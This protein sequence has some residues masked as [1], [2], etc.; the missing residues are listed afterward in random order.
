MSQLGNS[1]LESAMTAVSPKTSQVPLLSSPR[2]PRSLNVSQPMSQSTPNVV[3]TLVPTNVAPIPEN[4]AYSLSS[5]HTSPSATTSVQ[6][7]TSSR[8]SPSRSGRLSPSLAYTPAGSSYVS[9]STTV[10]NPVSN[11]YVSPLPPGSTQTFTNLPALG[12]SMTTTRFSPSRSSMASQSNVV[13]PMSSSMY[14]TEDPLYNVSPRSLV[15]SQPALASV[16]PTASTLVGL[17]AYAQYPSS[18]LVGS[19]ASIHYPSSA[20]YPSRTVS[21]VAN[22]NVSANQSAALAA[23]DSLLLSKQMS[24][25]AA[26]SYVSA[27]VYQPTTDAQ[28]LEGSI[29]YHPIKCIPYADDLSSE[30]GVVYADIYSLSDIN[31]AQVE[32]VSQR[33]M[34]AVLVALIERGYPVISSVSK[35]ILPVSELRSPTVCFLKYAGKAEDCV[36]LAQY[37]ASTKSLVAL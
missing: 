16:P 11:Q 24:K 34:P 23:Q 6:A 4:E 10:I 14:R 5:V 37:D 18:T 31:G 25:P 30:R 7:Q 21:T 36:V 9:P 17:P 1:T 32:V 13:P 15:S 33:P 26:P 35:R 28:A 8:M 20:Q 2:I 3:S 22:T 29:L 12:E 19:P 27:P